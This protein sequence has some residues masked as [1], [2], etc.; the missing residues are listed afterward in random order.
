MLKS[1]QLRKTAGT[2]TN[3]TQKEVGLVL[4]YYEKLLAQYPNAKNIGE[5]VQ[6]WRNKVEQ[7]V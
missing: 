4:A 1:P 3:L 2:G 5:T 7:Y 6:T